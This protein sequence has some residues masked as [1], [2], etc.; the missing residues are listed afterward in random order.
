M[1]TKVTYLEPTL[2]K[3]AKEMCIILKLKF[4]QNFRNHQ[5]KKCYLPFD[6]GPQFTAVAGLWIYLNLTPRNSSSIGLG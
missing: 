6:C 2:Q 5:S 3:H 1:F 4:R